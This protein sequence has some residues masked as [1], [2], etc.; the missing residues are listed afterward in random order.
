LIATSRIIAKGHGIRDVNRLVQNYG[1]KA[2][3]WVKRSSAPL[4]LTGRVSEV[5]WYECHGVGKFEMKV[6]QV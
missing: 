2:R 6:K 3:D 1:G 4:V 5:H